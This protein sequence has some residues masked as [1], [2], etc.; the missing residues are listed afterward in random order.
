MAL[1]GL[2]SNGN[3]PNLMLIITDQ[4]R[5]IQQWPADYQ[6]KLADKLLAMQQLAGCGMAFE[7]AFTG[8]CMC[9]PSRATFLTSQYPVRTGCTTTGASVLPLPDAP[10]PPHFPN[11]VPNLATV[12]QAAGYDCYWIGKWHLLGANP[13]KETTDLV[14]WGFKTWDPNDAGLTLAASYLGGGTKGPLN[15][16]EPNRNDQRYVDDALA[17]VKSPPQGP[18]CL[19]VS[20]V[21]PHDV[22]LGYLNEAAT[23]YD[24]GTYTLAG[25][26]IPANVDE[27]LSTKP[28]AQSSYTWSKMKRAQASQQ[29]FVDFYAW[30]VEYAD[31]QI[32]QVL[33][34]MSSD[35]I[36]QT[37]IIRFVDHG[38][39][40]L[41]HG[42]VEKFVNA[43]DETIHVPMVFSNP[44][45]YPQSCTTPV[46][47]STVDLLPT[48]A[49]LL[50]VSSQFPDLVGTDLSAVLDGD[51]TPVQEYVHFTYDDEYRAGPG[52][53][54]GIRSQQWMYSVYMP[55][56]TSGSTVNGDKIGGDW[57]MYDLQADPA[58]NDNLAGNPAYAA[59]Q[60]A[61]DLALQTQMTAKGTF[62]DFAWPPT[63][64]EDAS[65]GGPAQG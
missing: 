54:R 46:M 20:L 38:E 29:D 9:S 60:Q 64:I 6:Q 43:Y 24:A 8:A 35:L 16:S 52:V 63:W 36:D 53:I 1:S 48:L 37:L 56:T 58:Q 50:N 30:L 31:A 7:N 17:F 32:K 47:A 39:L 28:R 65:R 59:Q 22:H 55:S 40:G 3:K 25:A 2:F 19:V 10:L 33:D 44:I 11:G 61:L 5:S 14:P 4:Q 12:L 13:G 42:L 15:H 57:E 21:N 27:D 62:P 23:Y 41:S 49:S 51:D 34:S 18:F 45:A 26:P